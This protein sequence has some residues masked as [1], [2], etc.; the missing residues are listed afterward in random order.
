MAIEARIFDV[1]EAP[2]GMV[3]SDLPDRFLSTATA[4]ARKSP[5]RFLL[6][7]RVEPEG[8]TVFAPEDRDRLRKEWLQL[9]SLAIGGVERAKWQAVFRALTRAES[10][11]GIQFVGN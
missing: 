7:A 6:L 4:H 5:G 9:E 11:Q 1:E 8:L 10:F 2:K 3:L